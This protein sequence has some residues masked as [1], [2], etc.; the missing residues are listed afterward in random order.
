MQKT[1]SLFC[2]MNPIFIR[3]H[4]GNVTMDKS[5]YKIEELLHDEDTYIIVKKNLI[6]NIEKDL[7][8]MVT[9]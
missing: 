6:I 1:I 3:A 5:D 7:N 2:K 9:S 4:K 8:L